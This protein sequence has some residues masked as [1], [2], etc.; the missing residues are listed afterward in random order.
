MNPLQGQHPL[1]GAVPIDAG[2]AEVRIAAEIVGQLGGGRRLHP[3]V[4]FQ[5]AGALENLHHLGRA[6]AD[7]AGLGAQAEGGQPIEQVDV[8]A[9]GM[10]DAGAQHLDRHFLAGNRGGEMDLGDRGGG[11]GVDVEAGKKLGQRLFELG[12]DDRHRLFAGE[13]GQAVLQLG[14]ILGD[15][16]AHQIRAGG[17]RLPE[18]DEGRSQ[19]CQGGGQPLALAALDALAGQQ[20]AQQ[21]KAGQALAQLLQ[22]QRVMPGQRPQNDEQPA[23]IAGGSD[24]RRQPEWIAAMPPVRLRTRT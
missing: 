20:P 13:G 2:D 8:A 15:L 14:Q 19:R 9:E 23:E 18:L 21:R 1:G 5:A 7:Q 17:E 3:Q 11:D 12:L 6:Q 10:L 24:H 16:L 22:K 4:H